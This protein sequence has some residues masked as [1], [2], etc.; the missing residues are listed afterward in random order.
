MNIKKTML[1]YIKETAI[2]GEKI[3][4][5]KETIIKPLSEKYTSKKHSKV[6]IIAS[7]SSYNAAT[8]SRLFMEKN[9]KV[10]VRVITPFEFEHYENNFLDNAFIFAISQ[11]GRSTNII[12]VLNKLTQLGRETIVLTGFPESEVKNHCKT[13]IDLNIGVETVGYVTKGYTNTVL[14]LMLFAN[15]A[16][17]ELGIISDKEAYTEEVSIIK[18]LETHGELI[19]KSIEFYKKHKSTFLR[20]KRLQICGYGPNFGTALEGAL[21]IGETYGI[22][23]TPYDLEEFMHGGYLELIPDNVVILID[24]DGKGHT[25]TLEVYKALQV[26]TKKVFMIGSVELPENDYIL[27]INEKIDEWTSPLMLIVIFQI[28]SY[29]ICT[30]L[31]IWDKE[32]Y[33][34]E[35]EKLVNS[36]T[37][38]PKYLR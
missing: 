34:E 27:R 35:F 21:K 6:V 37:E 12:S 14:F 32:D 7:G 3:I 5:N 9:L 28:L 11:S 18:S 38:K 22:P 4:A 23:A 24:S 8:T 25:R 36:K 29:M 1:D 17:K 2:V 10:E 30:D 15:V 33:I 26:A 16:S 19:E 13:V 20:M 31:D